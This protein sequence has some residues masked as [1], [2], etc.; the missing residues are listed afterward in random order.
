MNF[1]VLEAEV[2]NS[3]D[4][5]SFIYPDDDNSSSTE[6]VLNISESGKNSNVLKYAH[7]KAIPDL[8]DASEFTNFSNLGLT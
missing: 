1:L 8:D 6:D 3:V 7:E 4:E 5:G 2:D